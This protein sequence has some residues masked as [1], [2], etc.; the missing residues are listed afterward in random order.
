M[1]NQIMMKNKIYAT[2]LRITESQLLYTNNLYS[3]LPMIKGFT[4]IYF[5]YEDH[6]G[7]IKHIQK[8]SNNLFTGK[9]QIRMIM[10]KYIFE[11][12]LSSE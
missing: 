4:S 3:E 11:N 7:N 1:K 9:I 10:F 8:T 12:F 5:R 6:I 2:Q